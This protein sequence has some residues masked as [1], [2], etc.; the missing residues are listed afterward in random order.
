MVKI[1]PKPVFDHATRKD[2]CGSGIGLFGTRGT[3]NGDRDF[4]GRRWHRWHRYYRCYGCFGFFDDF[5]ETP[6]TGVSLFV[7]LCMI[8]RDAMHRVST[9]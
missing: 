7:V 3:V 9:I 2:S 6:Y 4:F 1:M 5:V 8:G